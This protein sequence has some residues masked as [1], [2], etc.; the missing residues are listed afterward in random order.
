MRGQLP[1]PFHA[2]GLRQVGT[3]VV[4]LAGWLQGGP[5]WAI[6]DRRAAIFRAS[7]DRLTQSHHGPGWIGAIDAAG[8]MVWAISATL[9]NGGG[10]DYRLLRSSDRGDTFT[11]QGPIPV[12]SLVQVL[13]AG[14]DEVWVRGADTLARSPDGGGAWHDISAPGRRNSAR[15]RLTAGGGRVIIAGDGLH[16]SAD[17]GRTWTSHLVGVEVF[18][19]VGALLLATVAGKVTLGTMTPEGP[20]WIKVFAE[21]MIPFSLVAVAPRVAFLATDPAGAGVLHWRSEDNGRTWSCERIT[22]S[23]GEHGATLSPA[24]ELL[25][26]D[27]TRRLVI[28]P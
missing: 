22:P 13:A 17:H 27:L 18:A 12:N 11:D 2:Q 7:G 25:V 3:D 14:G 23:E 21:A 10:S 1:Q 26:L 15:E 9:R 28:Q 19:V 6:G 4:L 20:R 5:T 16:A 8:D 24:G